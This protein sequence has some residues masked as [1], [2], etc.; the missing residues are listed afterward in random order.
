MPHTGR[1]ATDAVLENDACGVLPSLAWSSPEVTHSK[2]VSAR[3]VRQQEQAT[4]L[5]L[6]GE[7]RA[8]SPD[9]QRHARRIWDT[10]SP[11]PE[12]L[13]NKAQKQLKEPSILYCIVVDNRACP[14]AGN[15]CA[16]IVENTMRLPV[17]EA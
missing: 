6:A 11:A 12:R 17:Q 7:G 9:W 15:L 16:I 14:E 4:T 5:G 1:L 3:P 13:I 2:K 10:F 8:A